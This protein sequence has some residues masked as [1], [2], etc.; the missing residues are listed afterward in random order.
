MFENIKDGFIKFISSRAVILCGVLVCSAV[1]IV[2][3]LFQLQIVKGDY[4]LDSFQLKITKDKEIQPARGNIYD[5]NGNLL[6]YNKDANSVT[7]EDVYKSGSGKNKAINDTLNSLI[8]IIEE[9]GDSVDQDFN[10]IVDESGNYEYNVTGSAL[11]RFLADVYGHAKIDELKYEEKTKSPDEVIDDLCKKFDIGEIVGSGL[12]AKFI[13]GK[14]YSKE[15]VLNIVIVRYK[16]FNNSYQKYIDTTVAS[17][18]CEQ[19]VAD[20]MEN[21]SILDGVDIEQGTARYYPDSEYF[22][23]ILGYTGKVT[24]E[25]LAELKKTNKNYGSNDIVGQA[26]IEESME[27]VLQGI[28]GKETLSVDNTG[29]VIEV[30]NYVDSVRG[31]DVW[32]TIDKD[33]T[34][35]CYKIL[36][37]SLAGI[38]V[39]KIQ[40]IKANPDSADLGSSNTPIPIYDVYFSIFD[41]DVVDITHFSKDDAKETEKAVYQAWLTKKEETINGIKQELI[42]K[43]TP[44]ESLSKE[45]KW[46]MTHISDSLESEIFY[47]E[48]IDKKDD[49]WKTYHIEETISLT[50]YLK[51]AYAKGWIDVSKLH[52]ENQYASSEEV[53]AQIVDYIADKLEGVKVTSDGVEASPDADFDARIYKYLLLEDRISGT[54]VCNILLEQEVV[55]LEDEEKG[56]W[57]RGGESA[58][59]FMRNRIENLDITPAQLALYP[60]TG[61]IVITDVNT[62]EVRA[63]VSYPGYDNNKMANGVDAKYYAKLRSDKSN[64]L[65]NYATMQK[66]AP[67][68]TFKMVS[69]TAGLCE[70]V[71]TTGTTIHCGGVF[72]KFEV[73]PPKCWIHPGSH[74]SLNVTGAIKNSCNV[75][76]YEV[77]YRLGLVAQSNTYSSDLGLQR[78]AKYAD[79]YGLTDKSGVEI[80]ESEPQVSDEDSVR[81]AIGQGTA[82]YTTV[83]LAR[84]VTTVANSGKCFNLTLIDKTTDSNN[85]VL[86]DYSAS[87]RNEIDMS[88]AY[89]DAIHLGMRQVVQSKKIYD[90]FGVNVAGKT[91]TAQ[92]EGKPNHSLFVCYAPYE[93][94]EIA[95][96]TRVANGYTSSYAAE[97]TKRVLEYYYDLKEDEEILSGTAQTLQDG[98][99]NAD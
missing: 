13:P 20:V 12:T 23:H 83:S 63:L 99:A 6:A 35:A 89:W 96:A 41:N 39:R 52:I 4:Y 5:V 87:V 59:T 66:T 90:N 45:Y 85:N 15:R 62:G 93:S 32:L 46:Y 11:L 97:I 76:F 34:E 2:Y 8:D 48:K 25:Q 31:N 73:R 3:R 78:L 22:S 57:E 27:S 50:E 68:S 84:Y 67:G 1:I 10:I 60:C 77:G 18:V 16:M 58:Y 30:N 33:L 37:Q 42:E 80:T 82:N 19:T 94:P 56:L 49:M 75:F 79:L 65:F 81:S 74:G 7:I 47:S 44:Y 98:A 92:Q 95:V 38:L 43:Q 61:S 51:Y 70:N 26:G 88:S 55:S 69:A 14:G 71:I 28:K 91:G 64:P 29:R 9:N 54:Q 86:E 36:E 40:N 53:F 17:D 24:P 72:D 21:A